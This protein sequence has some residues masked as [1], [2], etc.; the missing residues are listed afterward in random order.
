MSID[1]LE[2]ALHQAALD[3]GISEIAR[4]HAWRLQGTINKLQP[5]GQHELKLSEF[6]AVLHAVDHE[7]VLD[8]LCGIFGG[9]FA[10]RCTD[11]GDTL[12]GAV[13]HAMNEHADI[14]RAVEAAL[15]NPTS[16]GRITSAERVRIMRECVE[17]RNA[18]TQLENTLA[19]NVVDI[20]APAGA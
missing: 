10:T 5:G 1:K 3:V 8:L 4:R 18:I 16:P 19:D 15:H 14:G 12:M 13:L 17:A 20:H 11:R 7:P 9:R 6:V 2:A